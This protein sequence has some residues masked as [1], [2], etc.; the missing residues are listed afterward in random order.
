[1]YGNTKENI[2]TV[3]ESFSIPPDNFYHLILNESLRSSLKIFQDF[4][5]FYINSMSLDIS[6]TEAG[7][8]YGVTSERVISA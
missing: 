7:S 5:I 1:M 6:A 8:I 4:D 2:L 3:Q